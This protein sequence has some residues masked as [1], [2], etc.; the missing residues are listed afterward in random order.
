MPRGG[1]SGDGL[2]LELYSAT[3]DVYEL[4]YLLGSRGHLP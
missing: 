2:Y 1:G 4:D 3:S